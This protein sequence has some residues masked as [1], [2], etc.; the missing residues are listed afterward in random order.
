MKRC[1]LLLLLMCGAGHAGASEPPQCLFQRYSTRDG[2]THD[3]IADIYTDS[4]GFVW[5]C[6]WY[7]V[8]RFDG[9]AFRNFNAVPG[10]FTPLSHHRF[11]S[12]SED[13]NGH[14]WFTTYNLHVY[15]FNRFTEQFEDVATLIEG[16]DAKHYRTT[17]CLHD[18]EGGTWVAI[19][20]LGVVRFVGTPDER[21]VRIDALLDAP[22][23]GAM[24]RP[25]SSIGAVRHGSRR[26]TASSTGCRPRTG[27]VYV[28]CAICLLRHSASWPIRWVSIAPLRREWFGCRP[29]AGRSCC[30]AA[31]R[32]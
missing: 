28:R 4:R 3:R 1:L 8:S 27:I 7:G 25:C 11:V 32:H 9:Y 19:A 21:P 26:P 2:L 20:G 22:V 14:L 15:R 13:A 24:L 5:V 16:F 31:G 10:D 29:T 6:T 18:R 17:H 30:R 12:V 23:L